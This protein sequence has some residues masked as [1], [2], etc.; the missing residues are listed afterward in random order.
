MRFAACSHGTGMRIVPMRVWCNVLWVD[1][2]VAGAAR[3]AAERDRRG[4]KNT[5]GWFERPRTEE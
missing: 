1:A 5:D 4:I 2:L 3:G